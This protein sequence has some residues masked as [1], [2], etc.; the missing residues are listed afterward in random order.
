MSNKA[1]IDQNSQ[2]IE[3]PRPPNGL[4]RIYRETADKDSEAPKQ[5]L[6]NGEEQV[7]APGNSIS[8]RLMALWGVSSITFQEGET[9]V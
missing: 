3:G 2:H 5:R 7:I 6:L 9:V 4:G 8:H 1:V